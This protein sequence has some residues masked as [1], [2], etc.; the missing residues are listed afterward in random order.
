MPTTTPD[1][2]ESVL[3]AARSGATW[4]WSAI[5]ESIEPQ[6]RAYVRRQGA[7]DADDVI[8]ETWLHVARG[9]HGFEG[10]E[11]AFRSWVFM[12]GHHRI[13]DERRRRRRKPQEPAEADLLDD[14]SPPVPSAEEVAMDRIDDDSIQAV[15]DLLSPDQREVILLRFVGGF[16]ITEIASIVGKRPGAV[17]ALQRRAFARLRK[18]LESGDSEEGDAHA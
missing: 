11:A 9:I 16:G 18:I 17:Q 4:A 14:L 1:A 7:S 13:I 12:I 2:F 3:D 10:S 8:G 5:V 6:L 15:L